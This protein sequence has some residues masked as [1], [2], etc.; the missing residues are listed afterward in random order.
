MKYGTK[1]NNSWEKKLMLKQF[2]MINSY[3]VNQNSME[4]K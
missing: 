3:Q 2:M 1:L 4:M